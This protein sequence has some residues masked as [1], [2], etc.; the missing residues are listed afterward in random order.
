MNKKKYM[1]PNFEI[2][3]IKFQSIIA[4][5]FGDG[6]TNTME[7]KSIYYDCDEEEDDNEYTKK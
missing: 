2:E 3:E 4:L 1:K 5:S 7:S 6:T